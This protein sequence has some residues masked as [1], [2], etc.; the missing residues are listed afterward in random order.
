MYS[1]SKYFLLTTHAS[2]AHSSNLLLKI[3]MNGNE[4]NTV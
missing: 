2:G 3:K 4:N 1:E